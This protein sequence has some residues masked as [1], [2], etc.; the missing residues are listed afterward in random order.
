MFN[1]LSLS[2]ILFSLILGFNELGNLGHCAL[3]DTLIFS[4]AKYAIGD[5]QLLPLNPRAVKIH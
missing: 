5:E 4:P 2:T 3:V 1:Y